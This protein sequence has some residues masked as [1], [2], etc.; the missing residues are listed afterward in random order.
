MW[1]LKTDLEMVEMMVVAKAF[2]RAVMKVATKVV[3]TDAMSAAKTG[4][5]MASKRVAKKDVKMAASME[6]RMVV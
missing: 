5:S 4:G 2:P 6:K 3:M 1:V